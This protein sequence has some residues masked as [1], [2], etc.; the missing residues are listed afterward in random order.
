M[1]G[2]SKAD[3]FQEWEERNAREDREKELA[4]IQRTID[5][6]ID[7]LDSHTGK[8][9]GRVTIE[10]DLKFSLVCDLEYVK[11]YIANL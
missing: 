5:L 7:C 11:D 1:V 8:R 10:A 9:S 3:I 2:E 6:I 4:D